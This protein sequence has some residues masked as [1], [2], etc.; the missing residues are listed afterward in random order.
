V[1]ARVD[2][3]RGLPHA[4]PPARVRQR[5]TRRGIRLVGLASGRSRRHPPRAAP[6]GRQRGR[7]HPAAAAQ[8]FDALAATAD[9]W[10]APHHEVPG[11]AFPGWENVGSLLR[12]VRF[13]RDYHRTGQ[14]VALAADAKLADLLPRLTEHFVQAELRHFGYDEFDD[15]IAWAAGPHGRDA[16][17]S[18]AE[19]QP[20]PSD[21]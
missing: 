16:A 5:P 10:L 8:D 12:H 15:A 9:A 6:V 3:P 20:A 14:R 17:A 21:A 2:S 19:P 4:V 18:A 1:D 13:V 7:G 11:V